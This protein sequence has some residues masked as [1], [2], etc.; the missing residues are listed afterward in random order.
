[1]AAARIPLSRD[2]RRRCLTPLSLPI[3]LPRP[4]SPLPFR[5]SVQSSSRSATWRAF[6]RLA[7]YGFPPLRPRQRTRLNRPAGTRSASEKSNPAVTLAQ[8]F[9]PCFGLTIRPLAY[10]TPRPPPARATAVPAS[11][12]DAWAVYVQAADECVS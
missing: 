5:K 7:G 8:Y 10:L 2:P 4:A 9:A 11:T 3:H 12:V 1:M 6:I